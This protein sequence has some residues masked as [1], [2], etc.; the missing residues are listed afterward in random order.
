MLQVVLPV[1]VLVGLWLIFLGAVL[2]THRREDEDH[3]EV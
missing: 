2:H 3:T 1:M